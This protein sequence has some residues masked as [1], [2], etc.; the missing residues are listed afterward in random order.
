[1]PHVRNEHDHVGF[2]N[3]ERP[4]PKGGGG[5]LEHRVS[6]HGDSNSCRLD[7]EL[8]AL[9]EELASRLL[10]LVSAGLSTKLPPVSRIL[11]KKLIKSTVLALTYKIQ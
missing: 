9:T 5:Q 4:V 2:T 7:Q 6:P 10:I 8:G 1:M 3:V 11:H